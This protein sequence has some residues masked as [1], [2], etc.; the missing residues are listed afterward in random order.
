MSAPNERKS[1]VPRSGMF[2]PYFIS[3]SCVICCPIRM[4]RA[5]T[6]EAAVGMRAEVIALGLR[7]VGW[8][9]LT[10]IRVEVCERRAQ[11]QHRDAHANRSLDEEAPALLA[12]LYGLAEGVVQQEVRKRG[13]SSKCSRDIAE[14]AGTD[15]AACSPDAGDLAQ[16]QVIS[17]LAGGRREQAHA[18]GI[19]GDLAGIQRLLCRIDQRRAIPRV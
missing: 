18:L 6:V 12:R 9:P 14:Q 13:I 19:R 5:L 10:A 11:C 3:G 15:N 1:S 7:E 17:I 4:E 2:K 16:V 8:Q